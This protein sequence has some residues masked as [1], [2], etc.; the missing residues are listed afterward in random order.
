MESEGKVAVLELTNHPK[1]DYLFDD[2]AGDGWDD[3]LQSIRTSG[4]TNAIT[5]T[6]DKVIISGHQRVRACKVLGI[7]EVSYKMIEYTDDEK[8][9]K[10]LIESNLKQ[11]V[12]GNP[13]P[14][15][16]GRCFDFLRDYYGIQHGA[17][18]FQGNRHT[19]SLVTPNKSDS[20]E[21]QSQLA[22]TYNVSVDTMENYIKLSKAIPE[23]ATLIET[24]TITKT[25]ALAMMKNLS[26]TEQEELVTSLD[27]TKKYTQKQIQEYI[28]KLAEKDSTI[29]TLQ[30]R[31]PEQIETVIDNTDYTSL[32]KKEEELKLLNNKYLISQEKERLLT[33]RVNLFESDSE[34]YKKLKCEL[35]DMTKSKDSIGRQIDAITSISGFAS[36][37]NTFLKTEL[38]PIKYSKA[39][40][41]MKSEKTVTNNLSDIVYEVQKWCDEMRTY[42]PE[43]DKMNVID[44]EEN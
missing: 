36:K 30:S 37:I 8:Q 10:D 42:L 28:D 35:E 39:L 1:N 23:V 18:E 33:E 25:T 19:G 17:K 2:I 31:K 29:D 32:K 38:S 44:M 40:L 15:K 14:I 4:I 11:R 16:L 34:K 27:I 43:T 13:N 5:I 9:I 24:G 6:Q 21:T 3:L 22:N 20:L 41:E 7:E 12:V 26:D